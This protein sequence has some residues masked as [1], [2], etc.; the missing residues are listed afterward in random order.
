MRVIAGEL[1][2]RPLSAVPGKGTR[3][4]T[5]K[6]KESI[7]NMIGPYFDG[8]VALDLYAGTGGLGI[9]ALSRGMEKAIFV[10]VDSR[11]FAVVKENIERL[12]LADRAELY[13]NDAARALKALAKRGIPFDAVF[14]DP[15][16]AKQKI[17]DEIAYLQE[18]NL[19][20]DEAWIVAEHAAADSLPTAVGR[21]TVDRT[22]TYGDTTVT[23]YR[24]RREGGT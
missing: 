23:I 12:G 21:C 22:A 15:P 8:G 16:Y 1:K 19:L 14:L 7:F 4:T 9:E 5:D 2:G 13:R 24:H 6:V 20:A 17:A 10:E 18:A 11:A 3:P